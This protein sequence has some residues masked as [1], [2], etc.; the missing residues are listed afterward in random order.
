MYQNLDVWIYISYNNYQSNIS[1]ID[2]K[3][4]QSKLQDTLHQNVSLLQ[5][6]LQ[7]PSLLYNSLT[8]KTSKSTSQTFLTKKN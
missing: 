1:H 7:H 5:I 6:L 2:T 4:L 3:S 8:I